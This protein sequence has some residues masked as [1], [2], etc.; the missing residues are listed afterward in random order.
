V[1]TDFNVHDE[2]M[3]MFMGEKEKWCPVAAARVSSTVYWAVGTVLS[4]QT[5][6]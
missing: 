5:L 3:F 2:L 4:V 1:K 6:F